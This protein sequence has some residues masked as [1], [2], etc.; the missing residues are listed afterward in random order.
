V[1]S[2]KNVDTEGSPR[3]SFGVY[4]GRYCDKHWQESGY[5]DVDD[6]DAVFDPADAGERLEP[7]YP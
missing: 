6:P 5:R 2:G 7:D 1:D 4:A 3:Y